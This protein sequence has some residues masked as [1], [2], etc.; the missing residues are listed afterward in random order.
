LGEELL[1]EAL[2]WAT[3]ASAALMRLSR[4]HVGE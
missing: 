2:V 4:D 3:E 1:E